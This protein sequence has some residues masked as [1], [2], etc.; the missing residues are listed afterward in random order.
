MK[1]KGLMLIPLTA[2]SFISGY[3]A[4]KVKAYEDYFNAIL[5]N[6]QVI[7][8]ESLYNTSNKLKRKNEKELYL[9]L[10][11]ET[12]LKRNSINGKINKRGKRKLREAKEDFKYLYYYSKKLNVPFE[13]VNWIYWNENSLRG[14][15]SKTGRYG[16]M[17]IYKNSLKDALEYLKNNNS[18]LYRLLKD[19]VKKGKW[20]RDSR[21][22]ILAGVAY[23]AWIMSKA[24]NSIKKDKLSLATY[25]ITAY[26]AGISLLNDFV[27][28]RDWR[29]KDFNDWRN[30]NYV[31]YLL[32]KEEPI[33]NR[34]Y[35]KRAYSYLKNL[36]TQK[37]E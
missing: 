9:E 6:K 31:S 2:F 18:F 20:K 16:P 27:K 25:T 5:N 10:F 17:Q 36:K 15:R 33:I 8:S 14:E 28:K 1:I 21:T 29:A 11:R 34:N 12:G 22:N 37:F 13:V 7:N 35:I 30:L 26:H 3:N 23:L 32:K 19:S 24:P 4:G